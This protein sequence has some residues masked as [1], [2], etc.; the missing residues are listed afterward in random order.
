MTRNAVPGHAAP[1]PNTPASRY[2]TPRT[3]IS[4]GNSVPSVRRAVVR[5]G[6]SSAGSPAAS[7]SGGN[8]PGSQSG[9]RSRTHRPIRPGPDPAKTWDAAVF[10]STMVPMPLTSNTGNGN[11][12]ARTPS[13]VPGRG[14]PPVFCARGAGQRDGPQGHHG[15][16]FFHSEIPLIQPGRQMFESLVE[17]PGEKRTLPERAVPGAPDAKAARAARAGR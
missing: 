14:P 12:S 5:S 9:S 10:A 3:M 8:R 6:T 17:L 11:A 2:G 16:H 15:P 7:G 4:A 1:R 13:G